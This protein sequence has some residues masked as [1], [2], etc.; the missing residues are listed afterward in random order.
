MV[1]NSGNATIASELTTPSLTWLDLVKCDKIMQVFQAIEESQAEGVL[2]VF[3]IQVW[4]RYRQEHLT[5]EE[6]ANMFAY[7]DFDNHFVNMFRTGS[8]FARLDF[9]KF[10]LRK[11]NQEFVSASESVA[12]F[13]RGNEVDRNNGLI[14]NEVLPTV[15]YQELKSRL[16]GQSGPV[17]EL[18]LPTFLNGQAFGNKIAYASYSRSGNTFFRKYL[19]QIGGIFTGS[20]GDL[21]YALH[22]CLQFNGFSGECKVND[23]CWFIKTHYPLGKEVPFSADK[24]ILCVRN[25]L[26]VVTSMFNFWAS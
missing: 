1:E 25:P 7:F 9:N 24:V 15:S 26:D 2:G 13:H 12:L 20:D 23:E 22:Y 18:E 8:F 19:E 14:K 17:E 21:N 10:S 6:R 3:E 5:D 16:L 4:Q 11:L